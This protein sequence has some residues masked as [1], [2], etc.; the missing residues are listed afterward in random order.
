VGGGC[1]AV[2]C[3]LRPHRS[4]GS[5]SSPIFP[6]PFSTGIY[7]VTAASAEP[8][9]EYDGKV[10]EEGGAW[11]LSLSNAVRAAKSISEAVGEPICARD[12]GGG[13]G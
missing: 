11:P 7:P 2:F 4:L 13:G 10:S 1:S 3:R 8:D 6:L 9:P 12:D 5:P